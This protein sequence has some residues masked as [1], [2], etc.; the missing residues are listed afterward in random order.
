MAWALQGPLHRF[1]RKNIMIETLPLAAPSSPARVFRMVQTS[2]E[3]MAGSMP[4]WGNPTSAEEKLAQK[5]ETVSLAKESKTVTFAN[6]LA[7]AENATPPKKE[8]SFGFLDLLDVIN[9]LQHLPVIGTI[10][11][12]V[13]GD[14]IKPAARIIGDTA[15]G[16]VVG[17][18]TAIA[19]TAI[20]ASTGKDVGGH[21]AGIFHPS[22]P[23]AEL[24]GTTI[25]LANLSQ[26]EPSYNS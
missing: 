19:D 18:A 12:A 21:V 22:P 23:S 1:L 17:A 7:E 3:R 14:E 8:E 15:F 24:S 10:Y 13:T 26:N 9:P 16:G 5:L 4:V 11:R 2:G 6:A 25:A 20:E